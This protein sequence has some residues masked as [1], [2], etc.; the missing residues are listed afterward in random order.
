MP[1]LTKK[2]ID[3]ID[4]SKDK[5][6]ILWD[7]KLKGFGIRLNKNYKSYIA[8]ARI[9]GK[10]RR[11]TIG[12]HGVFT[13]DQAR[14]TA[15]E[16]LQQMAKGIDP[17]L[18]KLRKKTAAVTLDQVTEA[19]LK[20]RSLKPLSIRDIRKHVNNCFRSWKS[21]PIT[22]IT[23]NNVLDLFREASQNGKTQANQ[24]FR[25]LRAL[26][27][28]AQATYRIE[29]K[30]VLLENPV[31]ILSDASLWHPSRARTS[32]IPLE[33]IGTAW[34]YLEKQ[35]QWPGNTLAGQSETDLLSFIFLTGCRLNE[36]ASLSWEQVDLN[37][38]TWHLADPK[39][40]H[41]VTF[42]LSKQAIEILKARPKTE[43]FI[44]C[45]MGGRGHISGCRTITKK[46][47][48]DLSLKI[49]A[50]DLRRTFTA[51]AA[52][53]GIELWKIKLLLN[54]RLHGDVTLNNYTETSDLRYLSPEIQKIDNWITRQAVLDSHNVIDIASIRG[55][56]VQ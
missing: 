30:P 18:E 31:Q 25:I 11:V 1:N 38:H 48:T 51:V 20:D 15:K 4:I 26:L 6:L 50:H 2:F 28:Y 17:K 13:P 45:G 12:R 8:Q 39:N 49:T 5:T 21:Q 7:S 55:V 35:R 47:S 33:K 43:H 16:I 22:N 14:N 23:R 44:F 37:A 40:R 19:Y 54:H 10:T 3:S 32:R 46:L 53:C 52:T 36:G 24:A 34:N 42:P 56:H 27:N 9:H 41:P 29:D